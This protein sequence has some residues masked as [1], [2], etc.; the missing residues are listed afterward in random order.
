MSEHGDAT[1]PPRHLPDVRSRKEM[2]EFWDTHSFTDYLDDL[3]PARA[4]MADDV[5]APLSEITAERRDIS[6][7]RARV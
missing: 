2:A 7:E 3:E 6:S 5:T 1:T 4:H